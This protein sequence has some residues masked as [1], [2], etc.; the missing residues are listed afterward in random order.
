[1]K[2]AELLAGRLRDRLASSLP[3]DAESAF[4]AS[5]LVL[6][7]AGLLIRPNPVWAL[8]FYLFF[9]PALLN[10]FWR[11]RSAALSSEARA[12]A[13]PLTLIGYFA[14]SLVWSD[15]QTGA[16]LFKWL[17]NCV[18]SAVFVTGAVLFVSRSGRVSRLFDLLTVT[19][20]LNAAISLGI[21][22]WVGVAE[23][24]RGFAETRQPIL[25]A[26]VIGTC[27]IVTMHRLV[28]DRDRRLRALRG[29]SLVLFM[30]FILATGSRGPVLAIVA[31]FAAYLSFRGKRALFCGLAVVLLIICVIAFVDPLAAYAHRM[32]TR[33]SLRLPIWAEA[34]E[35]SA[36][37]PLLGYGLSA[38]FR[39][40]EWTF[41]HSLYLSALY[42]GGAIGLF[43]VLA[44]MTQPLLAAWRRW[45]PAT[46]PLLVA[47][48][49]YLA[50]AGLTD[51]GQP[52]KSPSEL[53][54]IQWLPIVIMIGTNL[55]LRREAKSTSRFHA[56][57]EARAVAVTRF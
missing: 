27:A 16:A 42:Y 32:L 22:A 6:L 12:L 36:Q 13:L 47:L 25:G 39:W 9:V 2:A 49:V 28:E 3:A 41:P 19:A 21:Y 17:N 43:L 4:Y 7:P 31:A 50:T 33:N 51:L 8:T 44:T 24:L 37:R 57:D 48:V 29:A 1:M 53:W 26:L 46:G 23:R 55:R 30:M 56:V 54:Y 34:L 11:R 38:Q 52:V 35:L 14:L 40:E 18:T 45:D 5:M 20:T 15:N 10:L